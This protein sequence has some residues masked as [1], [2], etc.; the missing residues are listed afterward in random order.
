MTLFLGYAASSWAS[1]QSP[2][3]SW[4]SRRVDPE[5]LAHLER[6]RAQLGAQSCLA[7]YRLG[8]FTKFAGRRGVT[9]LHTVERAMAVPMNA[10]TAAAGITLT[11]ARR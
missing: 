4:T 11:R 7:A 9:A 8:R 1:R 5:V 2:C 10:S 6:R 3:N